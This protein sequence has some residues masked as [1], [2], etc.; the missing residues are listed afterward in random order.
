MGPGLADRPQRLFLDGGEPPADIA[1]RGLAAPHVH[2]NAG[3]PTLHAVDDLQQ[4]AAHLGR[5]AALGQDV[6]RADELGGLA[7]DHSAASIQQQVYG[8]S[9]RR[10]RRKPAGGIRGPAFDAQHQRREV[11]GLACS[12]VKLGLEGAHLRQPGL[13]APVDTAL[14][15]HIHLQ[16]R[17]ASARG[18]I[19][20]VT[21]LNPLASQR[22]D[23][24]TAHVGVGD[25]SSE[26]IRD[27]IEGGLE[28]AAAVI[29]G[30]CLAA[31]HKLPQPGDDLVDAEHGGDD[32]QEIARA[33]LTIVPRVT[34]KRLASHRYRSPLWRAC[35]PRC[36]YAHSRRAECSLSPHRSTPHT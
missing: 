13:D 5:A 9:G 6:L 22:D 31:R 17:L 35:W 12:V 30:Q 15:L 19:D 1:R 36:A 27:P 7:K 25:Q 29:V 10:V 28:L 14:L 32:R 23:H 21:G 33:C 4:V 24:H 3:R 16:D 34:H 26:Q 2:A 20:Q 18:S 11:A 8:A